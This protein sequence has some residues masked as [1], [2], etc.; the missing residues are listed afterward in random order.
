MNANPYAP[1]S[2]LHKDTQAAYQRLSVSISG[3]ASRTTDEHS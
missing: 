3:W 2:D 1:T